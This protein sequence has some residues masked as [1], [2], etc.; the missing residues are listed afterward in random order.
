MLM[1][2]KLK[3]KL[4]SFFEGYFIEILKGQYE[5]FTKVSELENSNEQ[6]KN[7]QNDI[8]NRIVTTENNLNYYSMIRSIMDESTYTN[9]ELALLGA[10]GKSNS[11]KILICGFY[12]A[13]NLGDE[14]LLQ[15]LLNCLPKE[16]LPSVTV[17]LCDNEEYD[18]FHLPGVNFIHYPRKKFDCNILADNFDILI[19]GGGALIDDSDYS[20]DVLT[21]NNLLIKLSRRFLAFGKKVIALG[22]STN[23]TLTN[24]DYIED[25]RYVCNNAA[26]FSLRDTN[27]QNLLKQHGIDS[28]ELIDDLVFYNNLWK[29]DVHQTKETSQNTTVG[30]IWICMDDTEDLFLSLIEKIR[31]KIGNDCIIKCIPFYNYCSVDK[32]FYL[33]M[34]EKVENKD[35]IVIAP[36]SN[37]L[38]KIV[39]EINNT[40]YMV[41]MRYHG[42]VLSNFLNKK[43]VNISYDTHR[44]YINKINYLTEL[45]KTND[46]LLHFS[47]LI[48][49]EEELN[50][51][52]TS[53]K[54]NTIEIAKS[55]EE[56]QKILTQLLS[57]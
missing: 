40:D 1:I 2:K 41:N 16:V 38:N 15:S 55:S 12:G 35:N 5:L 17:M 49:G 44:H 6:L 28:T 14:L 23:Q 50:L 42:M 22:L 26:F 18:Y 25:L 9:S 54:A 24:E 57:K 51:N 29:T 39:A 43:S 7:S 56:L 47:K 27:S 30:V 11:P 4:F 8:Y 45:F 21:L 52:F 32:N 36:Y 53:P 33:K 31:E 34:L 10:K 3:Q 13:T 46:S 19:W 20:K 37:E 48:S